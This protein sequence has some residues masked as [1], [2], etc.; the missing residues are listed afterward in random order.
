MCGVCVYVTKTIKIFHVINQILLSLRP[1]SCNMLK[2]S[3]TDHLI[4]CHFC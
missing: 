1:P 2:D 3:D 4:F